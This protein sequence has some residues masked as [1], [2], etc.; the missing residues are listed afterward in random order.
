MGVHDAAFLRDASTSYSTAGNQYF[1][2]TVALAAGARLIQAQVHNSNG[3]LRLC[4]TSCSLL[5]AGPL[6]TWLATIKTWMDDNPNEVVTLLLVNSD[7]ETAGSFGADFSSSGLSNYGYTPD[8]TTAAISIWPTLQ[9]LIDA[10]TR[11]ISFIASI[12]YNSTYP[13]LLPEFTYVFETAFTVTSL[14]GFNCTLDRPST[15]SSAATA[16]SSGFMPLMNHFAD[17][18]EILGI[19]IP[20]VD[21]IATTNSANTT[22]TGMLGL[23]AQ[24]CKT[25]WGIKPTF[26]LIDFFSEG[27]AIDTADAM[28]GITATGRTAVPAAS[29]E[30]TTSGVSGCG[31]GR[32]WTMMIGALVGVAVANVLWL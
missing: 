4:H 8:S 29:T 18:A 6:T 32:N 3:T 19:T 2:V 20:D 16:I 5:D 31:A 9:T 30:T 23:S 28:N 17:T 13:Y 12:D 10:N 14:S 1:N 22:T 25:E 27:P 24:Q 11:L 15:V 26:Y 21:D 7:D